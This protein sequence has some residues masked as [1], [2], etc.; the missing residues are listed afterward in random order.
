V[1]FCEFI[2]PPFSS[3][4]KTS[5]SHFTHNFVSGLQ[6]KQLFN[7]SSQI[8]AFKIIPERTKKEIGQPSDLFLF[9]YT[10]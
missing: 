4:I 8:G 2:Q 10:G 1:H 6:L 3:G 9:V 5:K 7:P